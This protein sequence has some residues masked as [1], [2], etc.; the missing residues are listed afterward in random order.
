MINPNQYSLPDDFLWGV[1]TAAYQIEG[2]VNEDGRSPSIWDT[3]SHTPGKVLNGDTGDVACDHYHRLTSDLDLIQQLNV[4]AYRFSFSWPR[5]LPSAGGPVNPKGLDFYDR[6][7]DGCL[8]RNLQPFATLYHWDLPQYLYDNGGWA[9]RDTAFA[10]ADYAALIA[11]HFGDRL[12]TVTTFNEP[13][14]SSI[15]SFLY[16][17]HAPGLTDLT[18]T[19][20]VV[21]GQHLA[22]GLAIQAMR[23]SKPALPLG[24]VFLSPCFMVDTL[25]L[26]STICMSTYL[27]SKPMI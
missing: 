20:A 24:I 21:H 14:C 25:R 1:A 5:I 27:T 23:A 2:A 15:L 18:Q 13:W 22:H 26:Y 7:I 11:D 16:G 9:N 3:F 10:F 6:L 17:I 4:G 12:Q 19:L 8:E